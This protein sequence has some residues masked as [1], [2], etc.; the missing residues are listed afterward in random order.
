MMVFSVDWDVKIDP[1]LEWKKAAADGYSDGETAWL[2]VEY[3][4]NAVTRTL[5]MLD[6]GGRPGDATFLTDM[7]TAIEKGEATVHTVRPAV[8]Y[9]SAAGNLS[10]AHSNPIQK[11]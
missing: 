7:R 1:P 11:Q 4:G 9:D 5:V 8:F 3:D 6:S 2:A 10:A